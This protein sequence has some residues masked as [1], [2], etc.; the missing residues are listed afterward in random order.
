MRKTGW[1]GGGGTFR[2]LKGMGW[3][4]GGWGSDLV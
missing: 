1:G 4:A 2:V 3:W